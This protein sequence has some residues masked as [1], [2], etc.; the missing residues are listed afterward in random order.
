MNEKFALPIHIMLDCGMKPMIVRLLTEGTFNRHSPTVRP[1]KK[2]PE[3]DCVV[4]H[5]TI[6]RD[7]VEAIVE[8]LK[9]RNNQMC[10]FEQGPRG[11][12]NKVN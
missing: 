3:F 11:G 7:R 5:D 12:W 1:Y 8:F 2:R 9:Q 4:L 6:E 10:Y